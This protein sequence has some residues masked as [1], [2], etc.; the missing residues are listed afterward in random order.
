MARGV[1]GTSE[2]DLTSAPSDRIIG[3]MRQLSMLIADA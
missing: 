1:V 2:M 3:A